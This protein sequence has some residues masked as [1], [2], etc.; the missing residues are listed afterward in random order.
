[1]PGH[2]HGRTNPVAQDDLL[3]LNQIMLE[4]WTIFRLHD[5]LTEDY[6]CLI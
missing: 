6:S 1:M 3:D 5:R 2:L 4:N